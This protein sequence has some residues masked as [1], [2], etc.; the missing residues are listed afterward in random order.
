VCVTQL[1]AHFVAV[2]AGK[3]DVEQ[4]ERRVVLLDRGRDRGPAV[5][6]H[7]PVADAPQYLGHKCAEPFVVVDDEHDL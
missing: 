6:L 2:P 1:T 5:E 3:L 4:D 7:R